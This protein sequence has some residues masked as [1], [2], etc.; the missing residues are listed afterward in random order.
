M[1]AVVSQRWQ[2][3][4]EVEEK[5]PVHGDGDSAFVVLPGG[6]QVRPGQVG[7]IKSPSRLWTRQHN[8]EGL[9][10]QAWPA[11]PSVYNIYP[12]SF[13]MGWFRHSAFSLI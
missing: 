9:W 8:T 5:V 7:G 6:V 4:R 3:K 1:E 13:S 11:L 10:T 2:W 12:P